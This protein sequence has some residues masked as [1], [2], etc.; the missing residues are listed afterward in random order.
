MTYSAKH[1]TK[2]CVVVDSGTPDDM[3]VEAHTDTPAESDTIPV[4]A[5]EPRVQL[6]QPTGQRLIAQWLSGSPSWP[7]HRAALA[8]IAVRRRPPATN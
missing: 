7:L 5:I 8:S 1:G 2:V 3:T 4:L 6:L